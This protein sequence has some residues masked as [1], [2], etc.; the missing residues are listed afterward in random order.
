VL[1]AFFFPVTA[2]GSILGMNLPHGLERYQSP[3]LFWGALGFALLVGGWL[4]AS[5]ARGAAG[6]ERGG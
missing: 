6:G 4:R 3:W 2:L 5:L 1:A